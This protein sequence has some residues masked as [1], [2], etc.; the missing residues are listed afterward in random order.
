VR[1]RCLLA[2]VLP[3]FLWLAGC[4]GPSAAADGGPEQSVKPGINERWKSE[5]IEPL[6]GTLEAES[7]EIYVNRVALARLTGPRRGQAIADIGAGSGFMVEQFVELVGPTGTVY[8]VDINPKL[9]ERVAADARRR[10]DGNVITITCSEQTVDLPPASVDLVFIC[11]TYHHFEYPRTTLGS[12]HEA[13]RPGGEMVVVD[14]ERIPGKSRPFII[15]HVRAGREVFIAEI[16]AAG[17][18]LVTVHDAPF[19]EENYVLRFRRGD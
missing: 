12:I 2:A 13:L 1:A 16:E 19:L 15:D 11:D 4:Q 7:R 3:S 9:M 18:D 6:I 14:F 5:N 8:A 17:F 10:G